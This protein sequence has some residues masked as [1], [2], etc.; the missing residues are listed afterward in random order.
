MKSVPTPYHLD[1]PLLYFDAKKEHAWT[2]SDAVRGTQIFGGIGSGKTSGS[3]KTLAKAFIKAGYGG[4]VLCAKSDEKDNW[5]KYATEFGRKKDLFVFSESNPFRFNFLDYEVTRQSRGGGQTRNIVNLFMTIHEMG[6]KKLG[7][8]SGRGG[9]D[10]FWQ[11]ALQRLLTRLV[12]LIKLAELPM[13]VAQMYQIVATA[14]KTMDAFLDDDWIRQSDCAMALVVAHEKAADTEIFRMV[15]QFWSM[16]FPTLDEKTRSIISES[17]YGLAEPFSSGLLRELFATSTNITPEVTQNGAIIIMDVPVTEYLEL[18]VYAQ[19]IM[20]YLW[21]Q[22]IQRRK[23]DPAMLPN[24][25]WVDEAQIFINKHDMMFQ[26]T[27]RSSKAATVFLSQN[28]SNYYS[29]IGGGH[30]KEQTDSLLGNLSSK[31]FHANNDY[32][33]NEWA[34]NTIA[35]TFQLISSYQTQ[36]TQDAT[37]GGAAQQLHHQ[38]LPVDFTMLRTGGAQHNLQV[39]SIL[40]I[41]GRTW[42]GGKN[43]LRLTFDQRV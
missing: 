40:T 7:G 30:P 15:D 19:S 14:P 8:G 24:F 36:M 25:L 38:V 27:A 22:A 39:D 17:F 21:Q 28:I 6:Q 26:T 10:Q 4:L 18:G 20:K 42:Q 1:F 2:L 32:V 3:G 43:Y 23:S 37:S 34:S 41:A 31:I 16:E 29:T 12:D 35:K 9:D 33:T 13:T 11:S 5:V